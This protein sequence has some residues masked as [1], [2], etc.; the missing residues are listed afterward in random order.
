MLV[1]GQDA[2][3]DPG[4]QLGWGGRDRVWF[5]GG[6]LGHRKDFSSVPSSKKK[7]GAG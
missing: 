2:S 7:Q 5:Q 1:L 3:F 4:V 6:L